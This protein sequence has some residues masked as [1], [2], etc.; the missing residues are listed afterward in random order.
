M[1]ITF[2]RLFVAGSWLMIASATPAMA[3]DSPLIVG[4]LISGTE[5]STGPDFTDVPSI[6]ATGR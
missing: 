3:Q 2:K 4:F 1:F 5:S 6:A